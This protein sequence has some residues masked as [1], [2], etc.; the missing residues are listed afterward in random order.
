MFSRRILWFKC[1]IL[2]KCIW[3]PNISRLNPLCKYYLCYIHKLKAFSFFAVVL[4]NSEYHRRQYLSLR[5]QVVFETKCV[6]DWKVD[7][8]GWLHDNSSTQAGSNSER[9]QRSDYMRPVLQAPNRTD[10]GWNWLVPMPTFVSG[11]ER[12]IRKF[13]SKGFIS[14]R[15]DSVTDHTRNT[16]CSGLTP[17][18]GQDGLRRIFDVLSCN[19]DWFVWEPIWNNWCR[20][21]FAPKSLNLQLTNTSPSDLHV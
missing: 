19:I 14:D 4:N 20:S 8:T 12:P 21:Q 3:D 7:H 6:I 11:Y 5:Q 1:W 17:R 15:Y 18:M 16:S 13:I 10:T 9:Y 2:S